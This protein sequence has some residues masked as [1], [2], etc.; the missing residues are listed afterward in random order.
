MGNAAAGKVILSNGAVFTYDQPLTVAELMLEHPQEVVV[1]FQ[2]ATS[3]KK[4][5]PLPADQ[6]LETKKTYLMIPIRRG[7]AAPILSS[8]SEETRRLLAKTNSVLRSKALLSYYTGALPLF[9][10]ICPGVGG[11]NDAVSMVDKRRS[12]LADDRIEEGKDGI[13][14]DCFT[15]ILEGRPEFLSRQISGK[16]WKPSLDTIKEKT[17]KAKVSHWMF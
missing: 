4:P 14:T 6:K 10:R 13:E 5:S 2:A 8:S 9:A 1:E 11:K 15:E 16:G 17:I 7:K 3:G 12:C